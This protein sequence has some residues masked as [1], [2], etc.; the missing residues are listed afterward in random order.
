MPPD[1][2]RI[3]I[4]LPRLRLQVLELAAPNAKPVEQRQWELGLDLR[5]MLRHG[6]D[7][8]AVDQAQRIRAA[9]RDWTRWAALAASMAAALE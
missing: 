2:P 5:P 4:V 9:S 8:D 7:V 6:D 1:R 3:S